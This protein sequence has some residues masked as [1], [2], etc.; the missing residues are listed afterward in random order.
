MNNYFQIGFKAVD[1]RY[2]Y[3][4]VYG[5]AQTCALLLGEYRKIYDLQYISQK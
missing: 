3:V 1:S 4:F 2:I 5:L